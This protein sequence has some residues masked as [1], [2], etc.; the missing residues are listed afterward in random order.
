MRLRLCSVP[1]TPSCLLGEASTCG[2][3]AFQEGKW[4]CIFPLTGCKVE[5]I[6]LNVAAVNTHRD[7]PQV[8]VGSLLGWWACSWGFRQSQSH[9]QAQL[10][11]S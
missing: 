3:A 5:S 4:V 2:P 8:A 9:G 1:S 11:A 10:G 7:R 6:F